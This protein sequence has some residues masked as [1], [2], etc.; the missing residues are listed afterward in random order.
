MQFAVNYS[1]P[2]VH[3]LKTGRV[4]IDLL[5]LPAWDALLAPAQALLPGYVH[6]PLSIG[7]G[8]G[9]AYDFDQQK[10]AD[11]HQVESFLRRTS[12]RHINVHLAP[13]R[14]FHPDDTTI[15]RIYEAALNDL[16]AVV[17]RWGSER[18]IVE[19]PSPDSRCVP[20]FH[21]PVLIKDIITDANTGF[22]FD[23]SHTR[24]A[25]RDLGM[26]EDAYLRLLPLDRT[27][28]IHITGIKRMQGEIL[29]K[30]LQNRPKEFD[31]TDFI[32][33]DIDHQAMSDDDF[34]FLTRVYRL[35]E[36]GACREPW[37]AS[38]EHGGIG[39]FWELTLDEEVLAQQLPRLYNMTHA[40]T[41]KER[42]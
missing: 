15:E 29:Q 6:F 24:L 32:D 14:S 21:D 28:E 13:L 9:D 40:V 8:L 30:L 1:E 38:M 22:L 25:A 37:I 35:I 20:V 36:S 39:P 31:I 10:T 27:E 26:E 18:V 7:N 4:R 2:L 11:W 16:E 17:R 5:K 19:S 34:A 3:L 23:I 41:M 42:V 33:K 12:T